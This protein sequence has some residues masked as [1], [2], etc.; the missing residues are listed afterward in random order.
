MR[1][2]TELL[3]GGLVTARVGA[4][5][6]SGELQR[7]DDCFYREKD[8]AI[9]RAPGRTALTSTAIG[10]DIRGLKQL[11]FDGNFTEQIL[12]LGRRTDGSPTWTSGQNPASPDTHVYAAD[13]TATSGLTPAE[14]GGQGRWVGT[15]T[16]TAFDANLV[17][18]SCTITGIAVTSAAAFGNVVVGMVVSGTGVT[19]GTRVSAVQDNSNIT[20]DTSATNGTVTLTFTQYPFLATAVGARVIGTSIGPNVY[21]TAV[22]NQDGTTGHYKTATL[23]AAPS[24]GNGVYTPVFTCGTAVGFGNI[25][26]EILD[27]I[28]FNARKYFVWDGTTSALRAIEWADRSAVA[29]TVPALSARPVGL[30]PVLIAP[31][32]AVNTGQSTG[33]NLTKGAG[34]YWFL[35]TEIYS[36][37]GD[38]ATALKDP[39]Q[40][41]QII[42]GAYLGVNNAATGDTGSQGGAGL[43][44]SAAITTP[45]SDTITITFPAVQNNGQDGYVATHWGIY[46]YGPATDMPSLASMR[47][48]ATVA[49]TTYA[50]GQT[51]TLTDVTLTQ[52]KYAGAF[53]AATGYALPFSHA[54]HL[55]GAADLD[56]GSVQTGGTHWPVNSDGASRLTTFGFSIGVVGSVD[57]TGKIPIGIQVVVNARSTNVAGLWIKLMATASGRQTS[58]LSRGVPMIQQ[59][60]A[61][62]GPMDLLGVVWTNADTS[63]LAVELGITKQ[64]SPNVRLDVYDVYIKVWYTSVNVDFNGP[65][66]RVVTYRDQVGATVSD[67]AR[68]LPPV[69]TTGDFFQGCLVLND[70][71]QI[72]TLRYS[73]PDDPEAFPKPYRLTFNTRKRDRITFIRALNG[74]LFVGL[75]NTVKRVMYL[76]RET[77]TDMTSGL[78]H[79]DIA[80]DHGI[81]GPQCATSFD[82]PGKGVFMAYASTSGMFIS[83]CIW[84]MPLNMDLDWEN[85]VKISALGAAV[86]KNYPRQK[87]LALYYCPAGATHSRN[88]RV[89]YFSY[90]QDKLKGLFQLPAIGPSVV[91]ARSACEAYLNGTAYLL[92]GQETDG[93]VYL[94]DSGTTVPAGYRVTNTATASTQGD[95]K[96]TVQDVQIIPFIRTRKIYS[97]GM[98]RDVFGDKVYLMF[99][100]Y[101]SNS[102]TASS[103]LALT[104]TITSVAAFSL[105][106]P[107]MR[108]KG[109]GIDP[110]TIVL[111][112][113]DSSTIVVSRAPNTA[114]A[115]TL[116]F[117]TGTIGI[118][119]RGSGLGEAVKGLS[120][121]YVSTLAG[122]LVSIVNSNIRRGFELQIEK[123]PLTFDAN[124]DTLTWADLGINM[125][126]HQITYMVS[127]Q[128]YPDTNRNTT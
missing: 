9:W 39:I 46:I 92:T 75:E 27:A 95:G 78:A 50:A 72:N 40:K 38:I 67:P 111:S 53:A 61:F 126:L 33:W 71:S 35:I 86:L 34:N 121:D 89:M 103:T 44:L 90:Q 36:P 28:Q 26:N 109:T 60:I 56:Y 17:I 125:R 79:E 68:L 122:D 82:M 113:S 116:T 107:G 74:N 104:T 114:G 8:P 57:Y 81:P 58:L 31:T 76:P 16:S 25:G 41:L 37:N 108:V 24:G 106:V 117:D 11:S 55:T 22:S 105:I 85:T 19:A 96:A 93:L 29:T 119:I 110:G 70:L 118:G 13:F 7:A 45:A 115:V 101:G 1:A 20:L 77:D 10:A 59:G 63:T 14:V 102:F 64:S 2:V 54:D 91:S 62:G 47:R 112:K 100:P 128:G 80:T 6:E 84:T 73:L 83:N 88:T 87:L 18:A 30:K 97:A 12:M 120:T 99:S 4:M 69:C 3:N 51:Y 94:E 21:V 42:E 43:P 98:D 123:V 15:V 66:Y 32:L 23:N 48:C 52:Q 127:E 124:G 65:A 5:L 49:M